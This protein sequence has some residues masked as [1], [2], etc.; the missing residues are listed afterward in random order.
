M[1]IDKDEVPIQV[2]RPAAI[3]GVLSPDSVQHIGI[4]L[5]L[6]RMSHQEDM[7]LDTPPDTIET[8]HKNNSTSEKAI[9]SP[10]LSNDNKILWTLLSLKND[11]QAKLLN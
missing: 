11:N 1:D 6:L 9:K 10:K 2:R 8:V 7:S 3:G 4:G 5:R